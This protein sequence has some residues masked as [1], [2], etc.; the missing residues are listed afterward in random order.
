DGQAGLARQLDDLREILLDALGTDVPT[1]THVPFDRI[2][3]DLTSDVDRVFDV[4]PLKMARHEADLERRPGILVRGLKRLAGRHRWP[5]CCRRGNC[6][7]LQQSPARETASQVG[8]F[9]FRGKPF[10]YE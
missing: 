1:R 2:E 3:P 8:H 6:Q 9:R 4:R 10:S 5:K 7:E